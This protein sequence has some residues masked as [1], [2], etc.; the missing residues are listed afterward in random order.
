MELFERCYKKKEDDDWSGPMV[1]EE[2]FQKMLEDHQPQPTADDLDAPVESEASVAMMEQQ[3]WLAAVRGKNKGRVF[4]FGSEAH[5]SSRTFT[6]PSPSLPPDP[7]MED[8]IGHLEMMMADMMDMMQASS[9][10]IARP[11]TNPQAEN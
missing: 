2:T 11:L 3:M 6:S 4:V 5:V 9:S 8:C 1:V 10:T 7:V